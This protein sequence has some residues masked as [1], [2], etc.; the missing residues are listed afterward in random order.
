[1]IGSE[2]PTRLALSN[3]PNWVGTSHFLT[4]GRK[5]IHFPKSCTLRNIRRWTEY[6]NSVV[7]NVTLHFA[8]SYLQLQHPTNLIL[9]KPHL[10]KKSNNNINSSVIQSAIQHRDYIR[11]SFKFVLILS[12]HLPPCRLLLQHVTIMGAWLIDG[13]W[14]GFI[15]TLYTPFETTSDTA[16]S[17][18]YTHYES[19]GHAKSS[20]SSLVVP[21]QQIYNSLTVTAAHYE[22]FFP[23]PN[24]FL[25]ISSQSSS[26][27][28]SRDSL[29]SSHYIASGRI[30]RKHRSFSYNRFHGNVFASPSNWL[31]AK[32][33]PP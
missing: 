11:I 14:I 18:I 24:S 25:A 9:F 20:Q 16:L 4:W 32:N 2:A 26:T 28:D 29:N 27:A 21:W 13:F 8:S 31:F 33:L 10:K 12:S 3:V 5:Q 17:L 1:M 22:V 23:Q 6:K 30:H 15:D 7:L 19:V